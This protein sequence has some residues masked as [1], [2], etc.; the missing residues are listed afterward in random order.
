MVG[1]KNPFAPKQ[2]ESA[3]DKGVAMHKTIEEAPGETLFEKFV[4]AFDDIP[5]MPFRRSRPHRGNAR[6][7]PQWAFSNR[8]FHR[9]KREA[10]RMKKRIRMLELHQRIETF[11]EYGKMY[12]GPGPSQVAANRR[13][14]M[15]G[16]VLP[17]G[18]IG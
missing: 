14:R 13:R 8:F 4:A 9:A 5:M 18:R 7:A 1:F 2:E 15:T 11:K 3:I 10:K 17:K 6:R 16:R 12:S